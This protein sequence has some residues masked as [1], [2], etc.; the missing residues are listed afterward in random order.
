M[1]LGLQRNC[2]AVTVLIENCITPA[3]LQSVKDETKLKKAEII[4]FS[5][6][7]NW[8]PDFDA[9][10]PSGSLTLTAF[11]LYGSLLLTWSS[12]GSTR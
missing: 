3:E 9:G 1:K 6:A 4:F 2:K 11:R 10:E 5:S 7:G 12:P 8:S